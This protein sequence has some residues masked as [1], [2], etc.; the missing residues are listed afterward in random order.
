VRGRLYIPLADRHLQ[1]PKRGSPVF[2]KMH[3]LT[4]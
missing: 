1:V 4:N 3:M 2:L